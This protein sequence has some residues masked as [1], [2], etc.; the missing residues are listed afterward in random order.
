M[1][2]PGDRPAEV[3]RLIDAHCGGTIDD[4]GLRR[5]EEIL[6][7]DE[8]A[9]R[10]FVEYC[11]LDTELHFATWA[12][13]RDGSALGLGRGRPAA[14]TGPRRA[15]APPPLGHCWRRAS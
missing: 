9:R 5:L 4:E 15:V 11:Q 2:A 1:S 3:F 14:A 13:E 12:K 8:G 7:A 6:L 10:L